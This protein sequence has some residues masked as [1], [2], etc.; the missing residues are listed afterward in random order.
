MERKLLNLLTPERARTIYQFPS[1]TYKDCTQHCFGSLCYLY[2]HT[3]VLV[4][5][6]RF[7][8]HY[9]YSHTTVIHCVHTI[10][11]VTDDSPGLIKFM[12]I[13]TGGLK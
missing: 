6:S 7:T 13:I 1:S 8:L 11:Q 3:L 9:Q 10:Y 4:V 2:R 5:P 12:V